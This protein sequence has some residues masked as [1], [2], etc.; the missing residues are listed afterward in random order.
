MLAKLPRSIF[1]EVEHYFDLKMLISFRGCSRPLRAEY[2][3]SRES[4][5]WARLCPDVSSLKRASARLT[6]ASLTMII[7]LFA[8]YPG[9]RVS[10]ALGMEAHRVDNVC[11]VQWYWGLE[12]VN[13]RD[14][15]NA[16]LRRCFHD[17][18]SACSANV[19]AWLS[20]RFDVADLWEVGPTLGAQ[21]LLRACR[22]GDVKMADQLLRCGCPLGPDEYGLVLLEDICGYQD[23]TG[24]VEWIL[25][26]FPVDLSDGLAGQIACLAC[27]TGAHYSMRLIIATFDLTGKDLQDGY[28]LLVEDGYDI[29]AF[30]IESLFG[31]GLSSA[32]A[33][34]R[35]WFVARFPEL[36]LQQGL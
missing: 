4:P 5:L 2:R 24:V 33:G 7:P 3:P 12:F 17:A 18:V 20:E 14:D 26:H 21:A 30:G 27:E 16:H 35:K 23:F 8:K 9:R 6:A 29:G 25:A 22:A 19:V 15:R 13:S 11:V 36:G 34:I 31:D 1:K 28:N 10:D 32:P